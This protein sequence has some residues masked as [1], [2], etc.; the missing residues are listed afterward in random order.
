MPYPEVRVQRERNDA[1]NEDSANDALSGRGLE[2]RAERLHESGDG[3]DFPELF[4]ITRKDL[5]GEQVV[6]VNDDE[7]TS[8]CVRVRLRK[9]INDQ[10]RRIGV[11]PVNESRRVVKAM[12]PGEVEGRAADCRE[13]VLLHDR[14]GESRAVKPE[15]EVPPGEIILVISCCVHGR[16]SFSSL[17]MTVYCTL[18]WRS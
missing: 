5:I 10:R 17:I 9:K 8:L 6:L 2:T 13:E 16:Q 14:R 11:L 12:P 4:N 15:D 3:G 18:A 7:K 1:E